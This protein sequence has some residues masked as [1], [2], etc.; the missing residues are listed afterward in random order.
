MAK[1]KGKTGPEIDPVIKAKIL[2]ELAA[3]SGK[4][5]LCKKYKVHRNTISQWAKQEGTKKGSCASA[6]QK[7]IEKKTIDE[8]SD[9]G[10]PK[11]EALKILI[12][13]MKDPQITQFEGKG[14]QTIAT[15]SKDFKT[16]L[17]YLRDYMQLID[18]YPAKKTEVEITV[19]VQKLSIGLV[20]LIN[21]FTPELKREELR[22]RVVELFREHGIEGQGG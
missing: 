11:R 8:L 12:E 18:A 13:G 7:Q 3:G 16:I 21:D 17:G 1:K 19:K 15:P 22:G 6:V 14:D 2:A 9:L 20:G 5:A 4:S 10:M